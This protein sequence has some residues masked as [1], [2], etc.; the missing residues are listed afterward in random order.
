LPVSLGSSKNT[1]DRSPVGVL[2]IKRFEK[3]SDPRASTV[4]AI[5]RVVAVHRRPMPND[6][7]HDLVDHLA[8][9][10]AIPDE[11][12]HVDAQLGLVGARLGWG[13]RLVGARLGWGLRLY[14][15]W[16]VLLLVE[17][18]VTLID[19]GLASSGGGSGVRLTERG[20]R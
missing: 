2:V 18:G 6:E 17:A 5:E 20:E 12:R 11:A 13:L 16:L 19:D 15:R 3:G 7:G 1:G 10:T 8:V 14:R 9:V 4:N